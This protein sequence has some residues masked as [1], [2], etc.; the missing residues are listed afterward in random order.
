MAA[1]WNNL[2]WRQFIRLEGIEQ[3]RLVATYE[4]ALQIEAAMSKEAQKDAGR[5]SVRKKR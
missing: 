3:S 5:K 2:S 1:K 4:T